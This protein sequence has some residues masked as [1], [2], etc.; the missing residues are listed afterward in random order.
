VAPPFETDELSRLDTLANTG[1]VIE[2]NE[3]SGFGYGVVL[4][5]YGPMERLSDPVEFIDYSGT[6]T[7]RNNIISDV[8]GAGIFAGFEKDTEISY[9]TISSV[10]SMM[11][12]DAAGIVAG[13]RFNNGSNLGFN[14]SG[15]WIQGNQVRGVEASGLSRGVV[16]EQERRVYKNS[17]NWPVGADMGSTISSNIVDG[18]EGGAVTAGI[19]VL[20]GRGSG[21]FDE[22][23][24]GFRTRG[25]LV[26]NNTVKVT[27][28]SAPSL[29]VAGIGM[30]DTRGAFVHNNAIAVGG[31]TAG[32]TIATLILYQGD[33]PEAMEATD[34]NRNVYERGAGVD[35]VYFLEKDGSEVISSTV[36]GALTGEY[37]TLQQWRAWT[38]EDMD[39]YEYNWTNDVDFSG[40]KVRMMTDAQGRLP[41]GSKLNN[42]GTRLESIF[43]ERPVGTDAYG[44]DR[45]EAGESYDVGAIEFRGR[46]FT[47]DLE[48]LGIS[49]PLVYRA[50]GGDFSDAQYIMTAGEVDFAAQI[51]NNGSL[52]GNGIEVDM[53]LEL[54]NPDGTW[55]E[56]ATETAL[57]SVRANLNA[58]IPFET[59]LM[60][61]S[62]ADL[63][64]EAVANGTTEYTVPA[65]F[66]GM[67]YNV[68][69]LYRLSVATGA[70]QVNGNNQASETYRFYVKRGSMHVVVS[71]DSHTSDLQSALTNADLEAF[72]SGYNTRSLETA[73]NAIDYVID[74]A[75]DTYHYDRFVRDGWEPRS[76]DMTL[77][78]SMFWSDG[79]NSGIS[80]VERLYIEDFLNSG[81][82]TTGDKRNLVAASQELAALEP[83]IGSEV[84]SSRHDGYLTSRPANGW[85]ATGD[86]IAAGRS[87]T[88]D[89]ATFAGGGRVIFDA[90]GTMIPALSGLAPMP[91]SLMQTE[92]GNGVAQSGF[93]WSD[94]ANMGDLGIATVSLGSNRLLLGADWRHIA[95]IETVM[96]GAVDF[97]TA[98]DGAIVPVE[99]TSFE[100]RA[101][102]ARIDLSWTTASETNSSHFDV[103]RTVDGSAWSKVGTVTAAGNSASERG[104]S[105]TDAGL[106]PGRY[107]YRLVM[108]DRDGSSEL[109]GTQWET[110]EGGLTA[111]GQVYPNPVTATATIALPEGFVGGTVQIVDVTGAT[112]MTVMTAAGDRTAEIDAQSLPT[113]A[114]T[115]LVPV[116][117][118]GTAAR[119]FTVR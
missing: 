98:N 30:Q 92:S 39:S 67:E 25:D 64:E 73:L 82:I 33:N 69:P 18:L 56:V 86:A 79:L 57:A 48:A 19:H 61:R 85:T 60:P 51:R 100:T 117:G 41:E 114:Y 7:V 45:G 87:V 66:A 8:E 17:R 116:A 40:D 107:G 112:V 88:V 103:E 94:P 20:T 77:W 99:L 24:T 110:L 10:G 93:M 59:V 55:T 15:L 104:Y 38:G 12:S 63:N 4:M 76:A 83:M 97:L 9:N 58:Q 34:F 106:A 89:Y 91:A 119:A 90:N 62:Y 68:T 37:R 44:T 22:I 108:V 105:L 101:G 49:S 71:S 26:V 78:Q 32:S 80:R 65:R 74:P 96:R 72:A 5:G 2:G 102:S 111:V 115:A 113:G 13:G 31:S 29:L 50:T 43:T 11:A 47:R 1:N 6:N 28:S 23:Q 81:D 21:L 42:T 46:S 118:G 53:K 3:I 84:F 16:L 35:L 54:Q 109:S 95:D 14:N 27:P 70:D 52:A 36:P 75:T